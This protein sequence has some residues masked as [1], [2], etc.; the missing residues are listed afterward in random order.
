MFW[1]MPTNLVLIF[2]FSLYLVKFWPVDNA[3]YF[4]VIDF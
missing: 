1:Q 4:D 2:L 3:K